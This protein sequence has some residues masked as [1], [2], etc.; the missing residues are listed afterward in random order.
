LQLAEPWTSPVTGWLKKGGYERFEADN[1]VRVMLL[2]KLISEL[3]DDT[4]RIGPVVDEYTGLTNKLSHLNARTFV[5]KRTPFLM[6][7]VNRALSIASGGVIDAIDR[8]LARAALQLF[9]SF[10]SELPVGAKL[11][12]P[13][14]S[15]DDTAHLVACCAKIPV[16][17]GTGF[18]LTKV[19][20]EELLA[21]FADSRVVVQVS[22]PALCSKPFRV[23]LTPIRPG[24]ALLAESSLSLFEPEY[25][26]KCN[27]EIVDRA[28]FACMIS[29]A[30]EIIFSV[31]PCLEKSFSSAIKYFVPIHQTEVRTHNSF[32]AQATVG[33]IFVSRAYDDLKLVEAIVHEFHHNELYMYMQLE[34]LLSDG[35]RSKLYYSPWRADARPLF[36]LLHAC[37]V[38]TAVANY[39]RRAESSANNTDL[40][41]YFHSSRQ[42]VV[43]RL[44]WGLAQ[45]DEPDVTGSGQEM[46]G[47]MRSELKIQIDDFGTLRKGGRSKELMQHLNT[48]CEAYPEYAASVRPPELALT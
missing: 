38:F 3:A 33:V 29:D 5:N 27:P 45:I 32:S 34:N 15:F 7:Y 17:P 25:Q 37:Y 42:Q 9:D 31:W 20:D 30:L 48:W 47:W 35:S 18:A 40:S 8:C 28:G 23:N 4:S 11:R 1:F 39:M 6:T 36:G 10:F 26:F 43:E 16:V 21:E 13:S 46:V 44:L 14:E 2:P 19:S 12:L 41:W 22:P 24:C